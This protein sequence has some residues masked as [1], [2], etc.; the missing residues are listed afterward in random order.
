MQGLSL[1]AVRRVSTADVVAAIIVVLAAYLAGWVL[2]DMWDQ[3]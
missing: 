3:R 1:S 2:R